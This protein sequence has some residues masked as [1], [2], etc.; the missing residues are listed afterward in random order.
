MAVDT[1]ITLRNDIVYSIFVRNHTPE[2]TI[3]A[4]M[5][6]LPRIRAL[7]TTIVWLMPIQ[8]TGT[9]QRK[10]TL[11]SPYAIQDYRQIDPAQGTFGDLEAFVAQSHELGMRV[12]LDVV[13]NHTAP[14]S[15]LA[16][17][18]PEWFYKNE[19]GQMGNRTADW[20][21]VVDLD[22]S[23]PALW[24]YQIETLQLWAGYVDG[25]RCD[26]APMVPLAFW[27]KAR[28]DVAT[29]DPDKHYIWL[30]E[31]NH[32]EFIK[33]VR[34]MGYE[35]SSDAEIYQAF[36]MTYEYDVIEAFKATLKGELTLAEY[37]RLL[38]RMDVT[39]P[40]NYVKMRFLEN[41]DNER[42]ASYMQDI[43]TRRNALAFKY[44]EKGSMLLYAGEEFEATHLPS[45]FDRDIIALQP[46]QAKT[47]LSDFIQRFSA[48]KQDPIMAEGKYQ[49][50]D[51]NGSVLQVTYETASQQR[52]GLFALQPFKGDL[53]VAIDSGEYT[54]LI[55]DRVAN[56]VDGIIAF[57]GEPLI[58]ERQL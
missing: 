52:V 38:N 54:E 25:F 31:T 14:D 50:T 13:Y 28:A 8:P 39:Y 46:D 44:F 22:Y 11:G 27:L 17:T 18:H 29:V 3:K 10:G 36:D 5:A 56:V 37:A 58:L 47:D 9:V 32:P 21:D 4:A 24:D 12:I 51:L 2:G 55:T 20:S 34:D 33:I 40:K 45:L 15:V 26:V 43:D 30:A 49:V 16:K 57:T 23:Q 48:L 7:G 1:T 53:I 42:A 6:D 35:E 19:Q 41:H